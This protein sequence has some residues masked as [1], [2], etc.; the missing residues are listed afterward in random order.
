MQK[1]WGAW[2]TYGG[3]GYAFNSVDGMRN[4]PFAGWI[5]QRDLNDKFSLGGELFTQGAD[6]IDS[7]S[8]TLFNLGGSYNLNKHFNILASAG[9]SI[10]GESHLIGYL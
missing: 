5:L 6:S 2:T 10:I 4:H 9:H 8:Y 7:K 3:G 1:S